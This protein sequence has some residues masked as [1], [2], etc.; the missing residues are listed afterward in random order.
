[1]LGS[2]AWAGI[3]AVKGLQISKG[4]T[5]DEV[6]SYSHET[7]DSFPSLNLG[8]GKASFVSEALGKLFEPTALEKLAAFHFAI[9]GKKDSRQKRRRREIPN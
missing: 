2:P 8:I 4:A 3:E 6:V 7:L 1:M 9:A 5:Y